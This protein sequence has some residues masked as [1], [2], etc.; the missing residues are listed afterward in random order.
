M[1][2]LLVCLLF[3]FNSLFS[4][5]LTA[6]LLLVLQRIVVRAAWEAVPAEYL[7]E[8]LEVNEEAI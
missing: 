3:F 7:K 8:L 4:C 1:P 2:T 5:F 6:I